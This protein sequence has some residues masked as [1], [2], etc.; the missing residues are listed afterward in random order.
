MIFDKEDAL[1]TLREM[2]ND[3]TATFRPGQ[4][5]AV[6]KIVNDQK[7]VLVVQKSFLKS[8]LKKLSQNF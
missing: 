4:W 1:F 7:K 6:D 2:L 5:E 8:C 3:Q